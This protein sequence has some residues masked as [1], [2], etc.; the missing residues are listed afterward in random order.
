M[1]H[2][3]EMYSYHN[4]YLYLFFVAL[5]AT[6]GITLVILII[7]LFSSSARIYTMFYLSTSFAEEW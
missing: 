2:S 3:A 6:L 1:F 5:I 4:P 7:C